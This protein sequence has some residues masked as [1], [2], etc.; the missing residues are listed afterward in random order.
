M[1]ITINYW[2]FK[3]FFVPNLHSNSAS[4]TA[5]KAGTLSSLEPS[6]IADQCKLNI[7]TCSGIIA[8]HI[9]GIYGFIR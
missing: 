3:L 4:N 2:T 8:E 9:D 1:F 5:A 7:L 6:Q